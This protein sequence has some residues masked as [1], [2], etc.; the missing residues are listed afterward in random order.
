MYNFPL[1]V[2]TI[3][4]LFAL[5]WNK[6]AHHRSIYIIIYSCWLWAA[7]VVPS[8]TFFSICFRSAIFHVFVCMYVCVSVYEWGIFL[9]FIC[10]YNSFSMINYSKESYNINIRK[11]KYI[12]IR[13]IV[14]L[15]VEIYVISYRMSDG[16]VP[17]IKMDDTDQKSYF[18]CLFSLNIFDIKNGENGWNK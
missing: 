3:F 1:Y 13:L 6:S 2:Y 9:L 8:V 10:T 4:F 12:F 18:C 14:I 7:V 17:A 11:N 16:L 15:H 5:Y